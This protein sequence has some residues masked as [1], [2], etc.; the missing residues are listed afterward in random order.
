MPNSFWRYELTDAGEPVCLGERVKKGTYR[1]TLDS[2]IP[3]SQISGALWAEFGQA[4]H[5][6]GIF[7]Q[8][9]NVEAFSF[10]LQDV[11]RGVAKLTLDV[12]ALTNI[13][14]SVF[15][16][17]DPSSPDT[18]PERFELRLGALRSKG[19]GLCR[20]S[21]KR[22]VASTDQTLVGG[23]LLTRIPESQLARFD[24][25]PVRPLY[26]YLFEPEEPERLS[27]HYVRALMEDSLVRGPEFLVNERNK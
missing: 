8:S 2:C 6:V 11:A 15:I 14:A 23:A 4:Y 19:F 12:A 7:H 9:P 3:Y 25:E 13:R 1:G 26:G 18:L 5:A 10:A 27:G 21:S 20:L 17:Q 22:A 24:I 16:W